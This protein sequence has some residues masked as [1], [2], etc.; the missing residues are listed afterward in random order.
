M[1]E[2]RRSISQLAA[3]V[4]PLLTAIALAAGS[5]SPAISDDEA[6]SFVYSD[7][8][9]TSVLFVQEEW[10]STGD[11]RSLIVFGDGRMQLSNG[12]AGAEPEVRNSTLS[13]G[14]LDA[15]IRQVVE[16]GLA[17]YDAPTMEARLRSRVGD[18]IPLE[19]DGPLVTVLVS[20]EELER[21]GRVR[22]PISTR[23]QLGSPR[24]LATAFPDFPEFQGIVRLMDF[25]GEALANGDPE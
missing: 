10:S 1:Q 18:A 3:L 24:L 19:S 5:P 13:T 22:S 12:S 25:L 15:L 8:P 23:I 11:L 20:L 14:R 7:D 2:L 16:D 21:E 17:D 6:V 9:R 4:M